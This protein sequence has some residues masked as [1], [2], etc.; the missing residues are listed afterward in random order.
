M[1][2]ADNA[3]AGYPERAGKYPDL[4]QVYAQCS[5]PGGLRLAEFMALKM[6]MTPGATVLDVGANRGL[7]TCFLAKEFG[8]LAVAVDPWDDRMDARPMV[9]HIRDNA[10]AWGVSDRVLALRLGVPDTRFADA[11]FDFVYSTTALEM[12]RVLEGEAGYLA[13]LRE[14]HRV[15]KPNGILGLGEPMHRDV[16]IPEELL[17]LV[18]REPFAWKDCFAGLGDTRTAVE[19]AGFEVLEADHAPDAA[20]WWME[21]VRH[22]PFAPGSGD[23]E[24]LQVDNGRWVSFG[25]VIARK[26]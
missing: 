1:T 16:P 20:D 15:L 12:L 2:G 21:F 13:A 22:D 7:Q 11:S 5:G 25:Y 9:D 10:V 4:D 24:T 18:S 26:A 3:L 23:L 19:A 8:T 17:P 14:I 6:G